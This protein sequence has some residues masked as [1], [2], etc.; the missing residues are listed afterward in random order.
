MKPIEISLSASPVEKKT[1]E[2]ALLKESLEAAKEK[3]PILVK[4]L[5]MQD[6]QKGKTKYRLQIKK[7]NLN[8]KKKSK[9]IQ[10][11]SLTLRKTKRG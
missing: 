11:V 10:K 4:A 8:I 1:I 3:L 2:L 5:R 6:S 7:L 9:K